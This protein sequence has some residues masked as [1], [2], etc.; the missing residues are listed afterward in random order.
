MRPTTPAAL[1]SALVHAPCRAAG[2]CG[3][4][5]WL[6]PLDFVDRGDGNGAVHPRP[7]S[8]AEDPSVRVAL[9]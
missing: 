3:R 9:P 1:A 5:V 7:R 8:P 6:T 2:A 4:D